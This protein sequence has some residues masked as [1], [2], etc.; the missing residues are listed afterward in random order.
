ML[1]V[2]MECGHPGGLAP[3]QVQPHTA[4]PLPPGQRETGAGLSPGQQSRPE[5][6]KRGVH[7]VRGGWWSKADG[8]KPGAQRKLGSHYFSVCSKGSL[9][10]LPKCVSQAAHHSDKPREDTVPGTLPGRPSL[11]WACREMGMGTWSCTATSSAS[12]PTAQ[13]PLHVVLAAAESTKASDCT[14]NK[15]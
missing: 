2:S 15:G 14:W 13:G 6:E 10:Y 7:F 9:G 1:S 8:E 3:L 11:P 5:A 12:D 4:V